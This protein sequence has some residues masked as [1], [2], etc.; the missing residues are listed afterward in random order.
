MTGVKGRSGRVTTPEQRE[1]RRLAAQAGGLAAARREADRTAANAPEVDAGPS[2]ESGQFPVACWMDLKDKLECELRLRKIEQADIEVER[3]EIE[4]DKARGD[5]LT[6]ERAREREAARV[7]RILQRLG[8]IVDTALSQF[9]PE[10][11]PE[12]RL[13]ITRGIDA[14]RAEIANDIR[15]QAKQG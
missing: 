12:V 8:T 9:A 4:R 5:L 15:E 14:F 11:Q 3:A 6:A 2:A 10:R 13:A 7:E 1:A